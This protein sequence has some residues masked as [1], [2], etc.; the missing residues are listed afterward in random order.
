[1]KRSEMIG[2][3]I[4]SFGEMDVLHPNGY[5]YEELAEH[6]LSKIER[7]GMLAP[8]EYGT[9]VDLDLQYA[10]EVTEKYCY[11]EPEDGQSN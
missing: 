6:V 9:H 8:V 1:M 2:K 7:A 10:D 5:G 3:L 11:W 4:Q